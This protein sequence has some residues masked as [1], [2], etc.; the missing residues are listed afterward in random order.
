MSRGDGGFIP[1]ENDTEEQ[2]RLA[3]IMRHRMLRVVLGS[4]SDTDDLVQLTAALELDQELDE[5]ATTPERQQA[6]QAARARLELTV[7]GP[8]DH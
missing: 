3:A 8:A 4:A 1:P 5:L 2:L 6:I 7:A